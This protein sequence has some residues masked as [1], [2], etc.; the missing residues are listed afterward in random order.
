MVLGLGLGE[1]IVCRAGC[2]VVGLEEGL[3]S[4]VFPLMGLS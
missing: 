2:G 1:G 4:A 3:G